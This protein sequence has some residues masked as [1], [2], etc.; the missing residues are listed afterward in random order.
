[1]EGIR[2]C[3][4]NSLPLEERNMTIYTHASFNDYNNETA[5][6]HAYRISSKKLDQSNKIEEIIRDNAFDCYLMKNM[7]YFPKNIFNFDI[8]L[9]S[10]QN[11]I[12]KYNYG[13]SEYYE[14]K[15]KINSKN[16]N[17]NGFRKETYNHLIFNIKKN[18]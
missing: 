14:P 9:I 15:C 1:M 8:D 6:I 12:I 4:H 10:S 16:I 7:N 2:N 17:K 5:D 13:D 3:R 11:K 18:N